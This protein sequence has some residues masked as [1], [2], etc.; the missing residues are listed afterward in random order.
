MK[1]ARG[2]TLTVR[3]ILF[4]V[5]ADSPACRAMLGF[6]STSSKQ[7]CPRCKTEAWSVVQDRVYCSDFDH[8]AD[9]KT[10]QDH[11]K[12]ADLWRTAP[13][14]TQRDKIVSE[15]GF[16]DCVF[17]KL[18]YFDSVNHHILDPMHSWLLGSVKDLFVVLTEHK[19]LSKED[20]RVIQGRADRLRL[21]R[22]VRLC[23]WCV[24]S[25]KVSP[26]LDQ[27]FVL[28]SFVDWRVCRLACVSWR[29]LTRRA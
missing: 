22:E 11:T 2:N 5:C 27:N 3:A 25:R 1:T 15:H 21:P 17:L 13:N 18:P 4:V 29:V 24:Y 20:L 7:L 10:V 23:M 8:Q 9:V 28:F 12:A 26:G 14:Q 16:R 19:L 6:A